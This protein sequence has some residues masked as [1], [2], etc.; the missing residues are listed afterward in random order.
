MRI[1]GVIASLGAGGA[2]RVM[3]ELCAAWQARGD[4]VTLLTLDD[5]RNDFH[6]VPSGVTRHALNL[7]SQ[8]TSAGRAIRAN[9]TRARTL[10]AAVKSARPDVVVSFTDR[11]NVLVLMAARGMTVPIVVSERIDPR[12]HEIGGAWNLL[13]RLVYPGAAAVVVQ[14]DAV[15]G[16]ANGIV[17]PDRIAVI[18]NPLRVATES[19]VVAGQRD[20][21][22]VALGRL[23]DQ[24][25]FDVLV[26]AFATVADDFPEWQLIVYGEGPR[27]NAL[28]QR[29]A[30][31]GLTN[32][33]HLPG[34]TVTPDA[35]LANAAIF[36]LPSR[37]EGFPNALLEAMSHGC[38]CV[39]SNCDSG[40]AD[41]MSDG[42]NG[43]L[44]PVDDVLA[45]AE[46]LSTLMRDD[47]LRTTY[48]V[49]AQAA[50]QRF[51]PQVV[52]D[53]WDAVF[54]KVLARGQAAA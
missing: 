10:R 32:R 20:K 21:C 16:W 5:G 13:R 45:F 1:C 42:V 3:V 51:A 2:E 8:S 6:A 44:V 49:A 14:T 18:P 34:K 40:P 41:L 28:E 9:V 38:A 39:A 30:D 35:V 54:A 48:G 53:A 19:T 46:A 47:T 29:V 33:I 15:R 37:Y 24:K 50:V 52:L 26:R 11:T 12:R 23:V 22:I 4:S 27:R 25:G 7:A 17:A 43:R 36:A 31:L